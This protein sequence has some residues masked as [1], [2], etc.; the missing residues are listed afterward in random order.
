MSER[1]EKLVTLCRAV[2]KISH[3][4]ANDTSRR[5][6]EQLGI[7]LGS[8]FLLFSHRSRQGHVHNSQE[9]VLN[10]SSALCG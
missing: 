3:C 7:L 2:I 9:K 5:G 8:I 10:G 6:I 4:Q 1:N